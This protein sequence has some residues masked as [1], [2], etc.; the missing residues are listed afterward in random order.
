M[1]NLNS[2]PHDTELEQSILGGVLL[3]N[4]MFARLVRLE[5][6]DF[7][8]PRNRHVFE[9]MR[10]LEATCRPI[11]LE[12][13]ASELDRVGKLDAV[14]GY[15]YLGEIAARVPT[16]ENVEHY[17]AVVKK[18]RVSR[19]VALAASA[20]AA[21]ITSGELEGGEALSE[22][23]A[24][25]LR[26]ES[27]GEDRGRSRRQLVADENLAIERDIVA[28]ANG[29]TAIG[30]IPTGFAD[31]DAKVGGTPIGVVTL[32]IARPG[33][34]KSTLSDMLARASVDQGDEPITY[35]Y[36]DGRA[37][38]AQ[39]AIA[40]ECGV[41]TQQI[42]TR[43]LSKDE[44][45]KVRAG[46]SKAWYRGTD[47]VVRA[48]GMG[49]EE[50]IRDVR[51][52]RL[53]GPRFGGKTVGKR[54]QVDYI[55]A[56]PK[57]RAPH[58]RSVNDAVSEIST[59]LVDLAATEEISLVVYCQL[60]RELEK[61]EDHRPRLS[62]IRDCGALE[63]DGKLIIAPYRECDFDEEAPSSELQLLVLKNFQGPQN[64]RTIVH[65]DLPT[66]TICDSEADLVNL[67]AGLWG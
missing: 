25:A 51:A 59:H 17:A 18:H 16:A 50:L 28:R 39:R 22:L 46:V 19:D 15:A 5:V 57:P 2:L 27:G 52:R 35:S 36:E 53:R 4:D 3:R 24:A 23:M 47:I 37:T 9:A 8:D 14:G 34:G 7:Y 21:R 61:R 58:I 12:L 54:V 49:I 13:V 6:D 40:R 43:R 44:H 41:P 65:W 56:M 67:R 60:N 29:E 32:I 48:R 26:I 20:I 11:D 1:S 42:Q 55:Q 31:L 30:G 38:Y 62:D 10:N 66:H 63:Q 64:V 33:W 45:A